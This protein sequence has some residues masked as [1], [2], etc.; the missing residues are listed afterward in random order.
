MLL[1]VGDAIFAVI[2]KAGQASHVTVIGIQASRRLA[3]CAL[4]LGWRWSWNDRAHNACGHLVLQREDIGQQALETLGPKMHA[5]AGIDQLTAKPQLVSRFAYTAL[6]QIPHAKFAPDL[7]GV[8]VAA[9]VGKARMSRDYEQC[10][11][12]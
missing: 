12:T 2:V 7:L 10:R 4:K 6:D 8:D 11:K 5:A 3:I 1:R 9:L